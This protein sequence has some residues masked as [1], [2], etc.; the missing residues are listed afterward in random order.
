MSESKVE[1]RIIDLER[2]C[3]ALRLLVRQMAFVLHQND[4]HSK[5]DGHN[6]PE[7]KCR[8]SVCSAARES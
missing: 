6:S 3:E 8:N 4:V 7:H 1:D 5:E 2:T